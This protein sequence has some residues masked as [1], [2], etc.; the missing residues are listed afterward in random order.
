MDD[1]YLGLAILFTSSIA[2]FA[3]ALWLSQR[4]SRLVCNCLATSSI[5][6]LVLYIRFVWYSTDLAKLLPYSNLIVIG[7]WFPLVAAFLAGLVWRMVPGSKARRSLWLLT[8]ATASV[9]AA[10]FP[11]LGEPPR[12]GHS[13]DQRGF[14]VQTTDN[15]CSAACAATLLRLHGIEATEQEMAELCFTRRGTTWLGLYHGLKCKTEGTSWDVEIVSG[16]TAELV[17]RE[18]TP[19][20]LTVGLSNSVDAANRTDEGWIQGVDHSVIMMNFFEPG[21][22][23][24]A[25]PAPGVGR[26]LWTTSDMRTLWRGH[27][28]RLVR[29]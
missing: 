1:I 15:T 25:D 4:R 24:I 17:Q 13:W 3:T 29:R 8:L 5:I 9:L 23:E 22:F 27:G 7:N 16:E 19:T 11:F 10:V 21:Y 26:E 12:C 20:I 2:L 18:Q 6:A 14:C 28:M